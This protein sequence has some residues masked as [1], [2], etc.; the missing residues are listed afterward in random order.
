MVPSGNREC[1]QTVFQKETF[2]HILLRHEVTN[3]QHCSSA[4][5]PFRGGLSRAPASLCGLSVALPSCSL[6]TNCVFLRDSNCL[7]GSLTL[8]FVRPRP[9]LLSCCWWN[10]TGSSDL[11]LTPDEGCVRLKA[12]KTGQSSPRT[13][14]ESHSPWRML[15]HKVCA[16]GRQPSGHFQL[17]HSARQVRLVHGLVVLGNRYKKTLGKVE[18]GGTTKYGILLS[19]GH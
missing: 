4:Q 2:N 9:G 15:L 12:D 1:K 14:E 16:A 13:Q 18:E 5:V 17:Q 7:P 3:G 11:A 10:C 19:I 8:N 6:N